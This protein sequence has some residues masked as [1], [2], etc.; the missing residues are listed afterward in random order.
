MFSMITYSGGTNF[1]FFNG[2]NWMDKESTDY[3]P[4]I[5]SYG[6]HGHVTGHVINHVMTVTLQ[7]MMLRSVSAEILQRSI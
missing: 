5:T 2:A 1:G 7:T 3:Q 6:E 4:T